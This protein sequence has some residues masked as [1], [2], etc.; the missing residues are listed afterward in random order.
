MDELSRAE[1]DRITQIPSDSLTKDEINFLYARRSYF[2][3]SDRNE[4]GATMK[5]KDAEVKEEAAAL[6]A[7]STQA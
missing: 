5:I 4:Y 1:F 7:E 2:N 6:E 3:K